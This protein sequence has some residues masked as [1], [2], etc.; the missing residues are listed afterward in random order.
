MIAIDPLRS[1]TWHAYGKLMAHLP[2]SSRS[3]EPTEPRARL[4]FLL[5]Q[6]AGLAAAGEQDRLRA[7]A[8]DPGLAEE[9][10]IDAAGGHLAGP[11]LGAWLDQPRE[12]ARLVALAPPVFHGWRRFAV[13]AR[14]KA[15]ELI[16]AGDC[17][18]AEILLR[19]LE[20]ALWRWSVGTEAG[21]GSL[22]LEREATGIAVLR[23]A[24]RRSRGDFVGATRLL[25]D[26]DRQL[27][28]EAGRVAVWREAALAAAELA[29]VD[30]LRF[31]RGRA[32]RA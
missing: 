3:L 26:L 30:Q 16:D 7:L 22:G 5:G 1:A 18:E 9:I 8:V 28:D 17:V 21:E 4:P 27:L 12:A 20:E 11:L 15:N 24:C 23:A 2:G 29:G 25:E 32:E 19:T 14:A 13:A 31:P 10:L 6:V